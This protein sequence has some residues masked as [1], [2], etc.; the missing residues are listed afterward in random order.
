MSSRSRNTITFT[1]SD[2]YCTVC[3]CKGIPIPRK[4]SKQ[5]KKGHLKKLFC[6]S[7]KEETNHVEVRPFDYP[8][9]DFLIDLA[10]GKFK[11]EETKDGK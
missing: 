2:F 4:A 10:A 6:L 9:E 8:H 5:R 11:E 3:G 7:C 1:V